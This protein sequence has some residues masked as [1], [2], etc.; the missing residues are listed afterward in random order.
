MIDYF[1]GADSC[2]AG[3]RGEDTGG[4]VLLASFF[5]QHSVQPPC[6]WAFLSLF[7]QW[8][9]WLTHLFGPLPFRVSHH[10]LAPRG[11]PESNKTVPSA[12]V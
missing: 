1:A 11:A 6:P 3:T 10:F 2:I 5:A 7:T 12:A 9:I 8:V 4:K